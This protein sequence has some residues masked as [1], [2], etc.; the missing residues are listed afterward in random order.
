MARNYDEGTR[1]GGNYAYSRNCWLNEDIERVVG[2]MKEM[3]GTTLKVRRAERSLSNS[4]SIGETAVLSCCRSSI[5]TSAAGCFVFGEGGARKSGCVR[6]GCAHSENAE[7]PRIARAP[8][9][10]KTDFGMRSWVS[11]LV[12]IFRVGS[13]REA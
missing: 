13:V 11:N 7:K 8:P 6:V 1:N 12:G 5:V 4:R 3:T 2:S 9:L 10:R